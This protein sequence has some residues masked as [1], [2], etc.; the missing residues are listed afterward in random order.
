MSYI[1]SFLSL[2]IALHAC[3]T[4]V[5]N[6]GKPTESSKVT[7]P[8]LDIELDS[9][10]DLSLT[11]TDY[12]LEDTPTRNR[13]T[14]S[15]RSSQLKILTDRINRLISETSQIVESINGDQVSGVG[16]HRS[17]GPQRNVSLEIII[18]EGSDLYDY[19]AVLCHGRDIFMELFWSAD[20]SRIRFLNNFNKKISPRK[21]SRELITEVQIE[22]LTD[23]NLIQLW[24]Q[25]KPWVSSDLVTD[26]EILTEYVSAT[27]FSNRNYIVS[28]VADWSP[29]RMQDFETEIGDEYL[30]GTL[31]NSGK[32]FIEYRKDHP[33]CDRFDESV[34]SS[35]G[36]CLGG[37][38]D[39]LNPRSYSQDEIDNAW[40]DRLKAYGLL[41][42]QGLKAPHF[43]FDED[44][45][46]DI[47]E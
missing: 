36:W 17:R 26:G 27:Q 44:I 22:K 19:A 20:E 6:P 8:D 46:W 18:V 15:E 42:S 28:A 5:G 10:L 37:S 25:G 9:A 31:L 3:G 40:E 43:V 24:T 45:C 38:V 47:I 34:V 33:Q 12:S 1:L 30:V 35:P 7:L 2:F 39:R 14:I 23:S 16:A 11:T 21:D 41:P 32:E 13:A 4:K 29:S